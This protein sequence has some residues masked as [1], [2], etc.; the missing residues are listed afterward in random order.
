M[1]RLLA[2]LL[3]P[4]V[5]V[6]VVDRLGVAGD[7]VL[8]VLAAISLIPLAWLIGEATEQAAHHTGP[9]I[10]GLLNASFGN[11]PQLLIALVAVSAGLPAVVRASLA[12]SVI[13]D[14]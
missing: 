12:R 2:A 8:F 11:A 7:V 14:P 10:G 1:R 5:G 13:G 4:G 6:V 9:G 3:T